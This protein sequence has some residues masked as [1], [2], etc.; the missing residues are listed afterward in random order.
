MNQNFSVS[1]G[2]TEGQITLNPNGDIFI[3]QEGGVYM[4]KKIDNRMGNVT[5]SSINVGSDDAT[6][7]TTYNV[8]TVAQPI[9]NAA[10]ELITHLRKAL[11]PETFPVVEGMINQATEEAKKE[12]KDDSKIKGLISVINPL[13]QTAGLIP[14][15]V[16]AFQNWA[17]FLGN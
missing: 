1:E 10:E 8:N 16:E 2:I 15:A 5:G 14:S 17:S 13:I 12:D 6:A 9:D 7:T 11:T 4:D 3:I